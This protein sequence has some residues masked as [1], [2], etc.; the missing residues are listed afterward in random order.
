M[1][2]AKDE[3]RSGFPLLSL[4][5]GN[6]A[7]RL[8]ELA[9]KLNTE[10]RE[11]LCVALVKR[12]HVHLP[13]ADG[14]TIS[15]DEQTLIN[16]YLNYNCVKGRDGKMSMLPFASE[17][18]RLIKARLES[19]EVK[20]PERKAI[21][22][23]VTK[24]VAPELGSP[25]LNKAGVVIYQTTAP[26]WRLRTNLDFGHTWGAMISYS[27]VIIP[28]GLAPLRPSI[29]ICGWMGVAGQT[30]WDLYT[31]E[32]TEQVAIGIVTL[33]TWFH[34]QWQELIRDLND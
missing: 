1:Q 21:K 32:D 24:L 16:A 29:H 2:R 9:G 26:G 5:L 8:I 34:G 18:E 15:P 20:I 25:A 28:D 4:V 7:F 10:D 13:G 6:S 14:I 27:H 22:K 31:G 19:G 23:L 33:I 12:F 3:F 11:R 17:R 30:T